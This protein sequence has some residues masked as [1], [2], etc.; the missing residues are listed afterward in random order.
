MFL[1]ACMDALNIAVSFIK[2]I[3]GEN[4][5]ERKIAVKY[6]SRNAVILSVWPLSTNHG[7]WS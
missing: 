5:D 7:Y 2:R 3:R 6:F 4:L 1:H